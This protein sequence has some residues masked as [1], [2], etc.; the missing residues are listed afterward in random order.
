MHFLSPPPPFFPWQFP[1]P[2]RSSGFTLLAPY[3]L[4][5]SPLP[6]PSPC[7]WFPGVLNSVR[8]PAC[9]GSVSSPRFPPFHL[10]HERFTHP[11][12][13]P[14]PS[15]PPAPGTLRRFGSYLFSHFRCRDSLSSL[16]TR[17]MGWRRRPRLFLV[18][19]SVSTVK[20]YFLSQ[21]LVFSS[22]DRLTHT[23]SGRDDR[24]GRQL[25]ARRIVC[26]DI[27]SAGSLFF[28]LS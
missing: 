19:R 26:Y 25:P 8:P 10:P 17:L 12:V 4:S 5:F 11:V 24:K 18:V 6:R 14:V 9:K 27:L 2:L 7:C 1:E 21:F 23:S 15:S 16:Q 3:G 28:R 20:K 22:L 13:L